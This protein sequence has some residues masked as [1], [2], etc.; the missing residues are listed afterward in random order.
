MTKLTVRV[1]FCLAVAWLLTMSAWS[2]VTGSFVGNIKDPSGAAIAKATVTAIN[3]AT[4]LER[5]GES[6]SEGQFLIP[7]LPPG[8]YNLRAEASGFQTETVTGLRLLVNETARA[9]IN[10][11]L[12][13]HKENVE[14]RGQVTGVETENA[15]LNV[16]IDQKDVQNLPLNGRNFLQLTTLVPGSVPG[17]K[18]TQNFTPTT[19]GTNSLNIP[20]VN[21]LRE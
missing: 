18:E 16:V 14:V 6:N 11:Q 4:G 13:T 2:Q 1:V 20:Q 8:N 10:M 9:D 5:A 7:L 12:A 19:A 21:G 17:I 15:T 3:P